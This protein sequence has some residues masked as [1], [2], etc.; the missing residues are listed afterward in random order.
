MGG[1]I[2][3][4]NELNHIERTIVDFIR[5]KHPRANHHDSFVRG[6]SLYGDKSPFFMVDFST[7]QYRYYPE[8]TSKY[9]PGTF[10]YERYGGRNSVFEDRKDELNTFLRKRKL[11]NFI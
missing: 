2:Y 3:N 7:F 6:K 10:F 8:G 1:R 9:P 11:K 5:E 4:I